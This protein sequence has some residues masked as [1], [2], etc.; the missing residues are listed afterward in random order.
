MGSEYN[1][2]ARITD[3]SI[4]LFKKQLTVQVYDSSVPHDRKGG[5]QITSAFIVVS[6]LL[7]PILK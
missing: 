1:T 3:K 2:Q 7:G 5:E 6:V 4:I